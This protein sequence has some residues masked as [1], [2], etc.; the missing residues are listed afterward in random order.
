MKS[1][2]ASRLKWKKSYGLWITAP[3]SVAGAWVFV[4]YGHRYHLGI[5]GDASLLSS[6]L[7]PFSIYYLYLQIQSSGWLYKLLNVVIGLFIL[8][9][10][11]L[12]LIRL[13]SYYYKHQLESHPLSVYAK[14]IGFENTSHR[15]KKRDATFQLLYQQKSYTQKISN[16]DQHYAI[17]DS[18]QLII[19][20]EDP[21][22][23][24]IVGIKRARHKQ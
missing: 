22:I 5:L 17:G 6:L 4:L 2:A 12:G 18:L 14:I 3:V 15:T 8:L 9:P 20:S 1:Q 16:D 21:E 13:K 23:F 10:I 7:L 24:R 11:V 19:S